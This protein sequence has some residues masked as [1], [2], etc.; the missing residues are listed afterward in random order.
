MNGNWLLAAFRIGGPDS[1]QLVGFTHVEIHQFKCPGSYA[2]W[3]AAAVVRSSDDG[4]SWSREGLAIGDP[5]PCKPQFGGSGYSSV[6]RQ[7][8]GGAAAPALRDG[9]RIAWRGWGGCHGYASTDVTGAAGTWTRYFNGGFTEP[10]V[11]GRES[12]LPGL[13][14]NIAAP[15]VHWNTY[16]ERFV[17]LTSYW[18]RNREIWMYTSADGVSWGR[19]SLLVNSTVHDIAYGQVIGADSSHEAGREATL[20]YAANPPTA[21]GAHRDF[22]TR[23]I[24]FTKAGQ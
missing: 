11:G 21:P 16:L 6:L 15:I 12:C 8:A 13:G 24:R 19:P 14:A 20:V 22:V 18:G 10:G 4:R 23:A 7:P 5:Q 3:N 1:Q 2:E 9:D 17:M